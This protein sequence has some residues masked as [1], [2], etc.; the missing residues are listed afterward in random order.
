MAM[1]AAMRCIAVIPILAAA[2]SCQTVPAVRTLADVQ[3][4][5]A[6]QREALYAGE[7]SPT[8]DQ[9][10]D[11]L[12]R[13]AK[14]LDAFVAHEAAG[15]DRWNGRLMLADLLLGLR[16]REPAIAALRGL[17]ATQAS[18]LLLLTAADMAARVGEREL[19]DRL[20]DQAL[21]RPAPLEE[22]LA[23]ARLLM[24]LLREVPRGDKLVAEALAAAK[25][26][27]QRALV[28]W[29]QCDA[30][31]AREDLPENSYFDALD[32]LA[33]DLPDTYYGSIA[34]DR[35]AASQFTVGGPANKFAV[36]TTTGARVE[37]TALRG[38]AVLLCFWA[39]DA[40]GK[41]LVEQLAAQ[42]QRHG[43]DLFVLGVSVDPDPNAFRRACTALGASFLQVCD[44]RGWQAELALRYGV[45]AVP[46]IIVIDRAGA[47]AGLNLR[48]DTK[49]ARD[50]LDA[51][52]LRALRPQG[53]E[54][55]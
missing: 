21:Q 27:E 37:L 36:T 2:L 43:D 8:R 34:R 13:Q 42:Q 41:Q 17:D 52:I 16:E 46:T 5:F 53:G 44:G 23:M 32:K 47:I 49:D 39:A 3:R 33:K 31:R 14:E 35:S 29:Y 55:R 24:T 54:S 51:A 50:D 22:R 1:I 7:K 38:K 40:G 45:E 12:R 20:V 18:G 15:D 48:V 11:L 9:E 6:T 26:D 25:D 28:R 4:A 30:I 10:L 19:R